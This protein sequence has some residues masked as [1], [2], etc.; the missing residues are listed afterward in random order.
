VVTLCWIDLG[1]LLVNYTDLRQ[2]TTINKMSF[3]DMILTSLNNLQSD[4]DLRGAFQNI[5]NIG[6][7]THDNNG[8]NPPVD[9]VD[10]N[11]NMYVYIELP[12][13]TKSSIGV[14]F[15]NNKLSVTGEKLKRYT[16]NPLKNEIVYGNFM[17]K[18]TLPISVTNS[19]NVNV[20]YENGV[21][22]LI[23][24]KKKEE[25]NRFHLGVTEEDGVSNIEHVD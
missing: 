9:I 16:A 13:V 3:Q 14:D 7:P 8:W 5:I 20:N 1:S 11:N 21:L 12:G 17:R 22:T 25:E 10:T 4:G 15:F 18:I 19:G 6:I 24:D 2:W 23:V